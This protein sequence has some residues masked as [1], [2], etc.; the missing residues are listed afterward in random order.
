MYAIGSTTVHDGDLFVVNLKGAWGDAFN[1][2]GG[3][4]DSF[5]GIAIDGNGNIIAAGQHEGTINFGGG[6]VS[7]TTSGQGFVVGLN[8]G[9][10]YT[11]GTSFTADP[12]GLAVDAMGNV[13][14]CGGFSGD[15]DFGNGVKLASAGTAIFVTKLDPMGH[16]TWGKVFVVSAYQSM[17]VTTDV[18]GNILLGVNVGGGTIDFGGG[19][20]TGAMVVAKLDASGAH[21]WSQ[22]FG[23]GSAASV[24]GIAA[25]D[26][27][28]ILLGGTF[29]ETLVL[30]EGNGHMVN[31]V[32]MSDIFLAKFGLP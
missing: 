25:Y 6:S 30:G 12:N 23:A 15:V 21:V 31:S 29:R 24:G 2:G 3:T 8:V 7:S 16:A 18:A 14:V 26:A 28:Q 10:V 11:W 13:I 17:V 27:H 20:R 22:A 1:D 5:A 4:N 32:G 19:P 9:G